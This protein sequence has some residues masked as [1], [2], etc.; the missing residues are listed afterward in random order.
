MRSRRRQPTREFVGRWAGTVRE[1]SEAEH[2]RFV[3]E[4]RTPAL[5][6]LLRKYSLT[7]YAMYQDGNRL[8]VVFKAE[9]PTIIP[10][11]L[12]NHRMWPDFWEFSQP[13]ESDVPAD[14]PLVFRWTRD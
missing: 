6:E 2:Q 10:G 9:K 11:F 8:E 4:L 14:K 7:E 5:A 13:G 12:K 1:G 3:D